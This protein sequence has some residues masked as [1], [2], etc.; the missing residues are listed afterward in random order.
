MRLTSTSFVFAAALL[1]LPALLLS[2]TTAAEKTAE[3]VFQNIQVFKG[4]PANQLRP[5]MSFIASSL[6]VQCGFCHAQP[7]SADTKPTK[8]TARKMVEMVYAINQNSF[9]GRSEI[10][11]FTCHQG[12]SRPTSNLSIA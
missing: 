8:A 10:N 3:Q 5:T 2:Q 6:G 1:A 9:N 4:K 11:C 12:H 7:F